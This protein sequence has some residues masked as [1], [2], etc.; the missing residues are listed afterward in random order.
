VWTTLLRNAFRQSIWFAVE[1][2]RS[3]NHY[4]NFLYNHH[5]VPAY[6]DAV[7]TLTQKMGRAE[8]H[9]YLHVGK[10][11]LRLGRFPGWMTR[12]VLA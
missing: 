2:V 3:G 11:R 1:C 10:G 8:P 6:L 9:P 5:G 12:T 4:L 7:V